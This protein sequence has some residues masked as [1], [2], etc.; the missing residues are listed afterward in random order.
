MT[1]TKEARVIAEKAR[2]KA[3]ATRLEVKRT[4][5][6]LEIGAAKDEVSSLFTYDY[7]CFAFKHNIC[8][9]Q[10]EVPDGML[11][12]SDTLQPELFVGPKCPPVSVATDDK[13]V[14]ALP[15]EVVK[16]PEENASAEDQSQFQ[17]LIFFSFLFL[18]EIS[19]RGPI[20]PP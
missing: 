6:L 1:A 16:E 3:E 18:F 15:C 20:W 19:V 4:S 10:P 5:L 9:D 7:G 17:S 14:E 11:N 13:A 2:S 8:G 12:S